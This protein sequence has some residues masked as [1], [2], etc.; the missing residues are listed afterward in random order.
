M[1][2][3][4]SFRS[5]TKGNNDFESFRSG[6]KN[7]LESI[8]DF[9]SFNDQTGSEANIDD[10]D[11][12]PLNDG[13]EN[14][15]ETVA[16]PLAHNWAVQVSA[17]HVRGCIAGVLIGDSCGAFFQ[18]ATK[19][20]TEVEMDFCMTMPGGGPYKLDAGQCTDDGELT[21][22]LLQ[23]VVEMAPEKFEVARVAAM[24]KAWFESGPFDC[25]DKIESFEGTN[26]LE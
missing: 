8:N 22:C 3:F 26:S 13:D 23:A 11:E 7:N 15:V 24:Y 10:F 9:E 12:A 5:M 16:E 19:E 17:E 21:I 1:N 20:V 25:D 6:T 14:F 2:D 18:F 4:E